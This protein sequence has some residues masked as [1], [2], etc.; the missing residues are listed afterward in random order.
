VPLAFSP[1]LLRG[2]GELGI[3]PAAKCLAG[4]ADRVIAVCG[5]DTTDAYLAALAM[6]LSAERP[7]PESGTQKAFGLVAESKK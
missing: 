6:E 5:S 4:E 3:E 1:A 7:S 2:L